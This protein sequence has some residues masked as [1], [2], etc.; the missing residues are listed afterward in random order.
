MFQV[1]AGPGALYVTW[2]TLPCPA[3]WF[4]L[5][6]MRPILLILLL[7]LFLAA[8]G[9]QPLRPGETSRDQVVAAWGAPTV[10]FPEAD[11]GERLLYATAPLGFVTRVLVFAPDGKEEILRRFG[12]PTWVQLFE[13]RS[14]LIWEWRYCDA[15]LYPSRFNVLFDGST[16]I[17]R[18][19]LTVRED[20]GPARGYCSR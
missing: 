6:F 9:G 12:P 10:R 19:T 18:S 13:A 17:V 8:C 14:E 2:V 5:R 11:G 4:M 20:Y 16:G 15:W 7:P 1:W 3:D